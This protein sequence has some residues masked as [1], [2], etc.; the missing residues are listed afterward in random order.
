MTPIH[1]VYCIHTSLIIDV[2]FIGIVYWQSAKMQHVQED[3]LRI[4]LVR[5]S[6]GKRER[7]RERARKRALDR[8]GK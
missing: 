4:V 2:F 7:E 6:T 1:S 3:H 8:W 5:Q